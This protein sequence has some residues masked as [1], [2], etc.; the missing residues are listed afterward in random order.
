MT[1]SAHGNEFPTVAYSKRSPCDGLS[2]SQITLAWL[3][4]SVAAAGPAQVDDERHGDVQR[5]DGH[6]DGEH[7]DR[8]EDASLGDKQAASRS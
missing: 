4:A 6:G 3:P 7:R 1:E 5:Q 8:Q 2:T